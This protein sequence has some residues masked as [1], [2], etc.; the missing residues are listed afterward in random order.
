LGLTT[1]YCAIVLLSQKTQALAMKGDLPDP[2]D[3]TPKNVELVSE[4]P[5]RPQM[6]RTTLAQIQIPH[7]IPSDHPQTPDFIPHDMRR[8]VQDLILKSKDPKRALEIFRSR[9]PRSLLEYGKTSMHLPVKLHSS[10][11]PSPPQI[12]PP[13]QQ[14]A[15]DY[16]IL[17]LPLI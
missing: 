16:K 8:R 15:F 12:S 9:T 14:P 11:S 5:S 1:E 17:P 2:D 10:P 3:P 6:I 4:I 7:P 13:V